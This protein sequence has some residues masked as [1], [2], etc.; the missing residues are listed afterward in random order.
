MITFAN[1]FVAEAYFNENNKFI[2]YRRYTDSDR[3]HTDI[4]WLVTIDEDTANNLVN[5]ETKNWKDSPGFSFYKQ[6]IRRKEN[7]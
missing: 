6:P 4:I 5:E 7:N 3:E 1:E 2:V